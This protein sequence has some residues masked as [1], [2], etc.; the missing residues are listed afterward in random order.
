[1]KQEMMQGPR[2]DVLGPDTTPPTT[3]LGVVKTGWMGILVNNDFTNSDDIGFA[4]YRFYLVGVKGFECKID[5][6][7]WRPSTI[8]YQGNNKSGCYYMNLETGNHSFQMSGQ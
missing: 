7:N 4:F 1:M 6:G 2:F 8:D 5:D 3:E